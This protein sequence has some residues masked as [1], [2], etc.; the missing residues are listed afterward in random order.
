MEC[1]QA[2]LGDALAPDEREQCER[3]LES[4]AACQE[5]LHRAEE[6]GEALRGLGR[7]LGDPTLVP[8]DPTLVQ[9]LERLHEGPGPS[10]TPPAEAPDLFFLRPADRP[11]V[12]GMLGGYEVREVIGQGGMGVVLKA[13]DLAL[14]RPVAIKVLAAALAGSATARRRFTREAQAAAAVSHDHIVAVHRVSEADGVP[15]LVMQYVPG[16]SLQQRLDRA[17]PLEVADTVR[18]GLQT[19]QGLAAAHA[20]G[21]IHR[22]VKPANI[23]LENGLGRV[24]VTDFGLARMADDAGL[25]QAGV[26]AGTPEYMAPEQA[27]GEQVDAR[28]D[29]FSLGSVL[30]A[31]CTG[32]PPFRGPTPLAVL[33]QVSDETPAP[34][35]SLNPDVPAWLEALVARLLAKDPARR[36]QTAAE[37]A[38]LLEGY[39]AHLRQPA[40]VPAP[41]LPPP[42]DRNLQRPAP[43]PRAEVVKWFL[44]ALGLAA[45]VLG[46]LGLSQW[47][48]TQA[49]P[50][51]PPAQ[52]SRGEFYH[53]FRG[54]KPLPPCFRPIG[55]DAEDRMRP[56]DAGWRITLPAERDSTDRVGLEMDS[57]IKGDFEI[58]AGYEILRADR[59]HTGYGVGFE[60]FIVI[61]T[62]A[63]DGLGVY[64]VARVR[65]GEV[66]MVSRNGEEGGTRTYRQKYIP[67]TATSGRLRVT[68]AGRRATLWAAQGAADDFVE[69]C[70]YDLGA[71]DVDKVWLAAFPGSSTSAVDLRL[72]DLK[73]RSDNPVAAQPADATPAA[74]PQQPGQRGWLAAAGAVGLAVVC[75]LLVVAWLAV[76]RRGAAPTPAPDA[77]ANP[78]ARP[79][80]S[81]PC[82][83]CGHTLRVRPEL[84]GKKGKCPHC[85][86]AVRIPAT[87]AGEP[88]DPSR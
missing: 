36:F 71:E 66:Y 88:H 19:A 35:R 61:A 29:L 6:C 14:Q 57:P 34:V 54:H 15:Y 9:V 1:W 41:V 52:P 24:K 38:A 21:L 49:P 27:R 44:P 80:I 42:P 18:I 50:P 7:R 32:V 30:Y 56:E 33:R 60:L 84:A 87:D 68:R 62:P 55:P 43:G 22:D 85:H 17:G 45:V 37:V 63:Q 78:G 26:V 40:T 83:A 81:F 59:P 74:L 77:G 69:L 39:L 10:R 13:F 3:H 79:T 51:L 5:R 72:V 8:A 16:E 20:Q 53:D 73:V 31:C 70:A 75:T 47:L 76:R 2:L 86:E 46:G 48:L 65:E 28:C 82:P 58:T 12:L 25:T 4:C 67:T 11:G 23:L 64:R